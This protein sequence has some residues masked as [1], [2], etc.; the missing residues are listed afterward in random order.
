MG[1]GL[2]LCGLVMVSTYSFLNKSIAYMREASLSI[3]FPNN[4]L[5]SGFDKKPKT[6]KRKCLTRGL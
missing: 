4:E 6:Y 3:R 1:F 5:I 2:C